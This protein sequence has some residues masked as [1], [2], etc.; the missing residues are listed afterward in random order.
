MKYVKPIILVMIVV[1]FIFLGVN[2][3]VT[4]NNKIKLKEIEIKSLGIKLNDV[5]KKYDLLNK[6]L[7]KIKTTSEQE[8]QGLQ[9]EKRKLEEEKR[10]LEAELQAKRDRLN[11]SSNRALATQTVAASSEQCAAWM[12][13]AG[14]PNT[15]ASREVIRRESN[16]RPTARNSS[17]G[18]C[19]IAQALPCSKM[20]CPVENTSTAAICQLRW[21]QQYVINR[22]GSWDSALAW[23]NSHNWY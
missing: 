22:Y 21:M 10:K 11:N 12:A 19:G 23:H 7:E 16:C 4:N 9:E 20:G 15:A 18:A 1:T 13:A 8:K 2:N 17:S 6:D 3:I 14:V 5:N